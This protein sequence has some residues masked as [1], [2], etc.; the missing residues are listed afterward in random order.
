LQVGEI[1]EWLDFSGPVQSI[2]NIKGETAA[3]RTVEMVKQK[4]ED[5]AVGHDGAEMAIRHEVEEEVRREGR[6]EMRREVDGPLGSWGKPG[7]SG[8]WRVKPAAEKR[9]NGPSISGWARVAK[10]A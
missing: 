6:R 8:G 2:E 5:R 10:V 4:A 9:T 1:G 3:M 7:A